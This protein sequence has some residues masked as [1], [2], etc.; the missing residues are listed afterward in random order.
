MFWAAIFL[1]CISCCARDNVFVWETKYAKERERERERERTVSHSIFV[2]EWY[3]RGAY[4]QRLPCVSWLP[5]NNDSF[6]LFVYVCWSR[7]C[8]YLVGATGNIEAALK[9]HRIVRSDGFEYNV[10]HTN[11]DT[12]SPITTHIFFLLLLCSKQQQQQHKRQ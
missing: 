5:L 6:C 9:Q 8:V 12:R 3:I 4:T 1:A 2:C 7:L 11:Y 10:L